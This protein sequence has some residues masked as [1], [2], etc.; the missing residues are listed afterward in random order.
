MN[1][2]F[3]EIQQR[4]LAVLIE[5]HGETVTLTQNSTDAVI[6]MMIVSV[7]DAPNWV[8]EYRQRDETNWFI[9]RV[10]GSDLP[11]GLS[12]KV[13]VTDSVGAKFTMQDFKPIGRPLN[14]KFVGY[15]LALVTNTR[16]G[17]L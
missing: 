10:V 12:A 4:D 5:E 6:S 13:T 3:F 8:R 15:M 1:E 14:G 7:P 9:G 16:L 17:G 2:S 11:T